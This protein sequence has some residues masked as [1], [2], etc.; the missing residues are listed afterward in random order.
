MLEKDREA[1]ICDM[2][3]TYQIYEIW[4]FPTTYIATLAAGLSE[5]SRIKRT[6]SQS[7]TDKNTYMQALQVDLLQFLLWS[8]T[9]DAQHGRNKPELLSE[10][11]T[12]KKETV[13]MTMEEFRE[14]RKRVIHA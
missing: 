5:D 8:K 10:K 3:E 7:I 14:L 11:L 9:K 6:L 13:S 12:R 2:A 4:D 1:L